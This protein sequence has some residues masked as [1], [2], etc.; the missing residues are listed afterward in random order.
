MGRKARTNF[1]R[2]TE[3]LPFLFMMD[4]DH[5]IALDDK[6]ASTGGDS[7]PLP[8]TWMARTSVSATKSAR[9]CPATTSPTL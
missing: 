5:G 8:P 7:P 6:D 4:R 9:L 1:S 3:L 2:Y